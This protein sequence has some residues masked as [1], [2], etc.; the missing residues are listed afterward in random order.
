MNSNDSPRPRLV[1]D[2]NVIVGALFSRRRHSLLDYWRQGRFDLLVSAAIAAEYQTIL[3]HFQRLQARAVSQFFNDVAARAVRVTVP[4]SL[5]L[6]SNDPS[7]NKFCDCAES[8]AA[9]VLVSADRHLHA[10]Q[11]HV[12]VAIERPRTVLRWLDDGRWPGVERQA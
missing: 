6:V 9:D 2:T 11:V 7:D 8:A 12:R 10:V 4:G 1:C 3:K 5:N